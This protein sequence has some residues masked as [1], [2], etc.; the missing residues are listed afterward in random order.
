MFGF[1]L[2]TSLNLTLS[3]CPM[4]RLASTSCE[5]V[6]T[7]ASSLKVL[8]SLRYSYSPSDTHCK[9]SSDNLHLISFI[10]TTCCSISSIL[11]SLLK[12]KYFISSTISLSINA[13]SAS[14]LVTLNY[15]S[16]I[17]MVLF[18]VFCKSFATPKEAL[19]KSNCEVSIFILDSVLF[20]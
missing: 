16:P 14:M 9:K 6:S 1:S 3:P 2:V 15:I 18:V 17:F 13:D 12:K 7:I 5:I 19:A 11:S 10:I 4:L 20:M 8:L